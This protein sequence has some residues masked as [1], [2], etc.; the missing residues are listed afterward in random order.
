[1]SCIPSNAMGCVNTMLN[2]VTNFDWIELTDWMFWSID[3]AAKRVRTVVKPATWY[4]EEWQ[5]F[6]K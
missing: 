5:V 1:M 4:D 6:Q 2:I 3:T